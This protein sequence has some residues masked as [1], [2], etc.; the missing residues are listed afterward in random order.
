MISLDISLESRSPLEIETK[1]QLEA[2]VSKYDLES[3]IFTNHI[4]IQEGCIPHSHPVLTLN[5]ACL[6]SDEDLL[7]NF[8][9]EQMHWYVSSKKQ[10]MFAAVD[11]LKKEFSNL[12]TEP[13]QIAHNEFSTYLHLIINRLEYEGLARYVGVERAHQAIESKGYYTWIYEQI[14]QAPEM[15]IC[16]IN[17]YGLRL[18]E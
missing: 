16:I 11:A 17:Q 12:P 1:S 15:I 6:D 18:P 10:A 7:S 14:L 9:H 2:L 3:L 13:S 4:H 5:T 8:I